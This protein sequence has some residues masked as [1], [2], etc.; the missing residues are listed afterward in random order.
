MVVAMQILTVTQLNMY[1]R[2]LLDTDPIVQDIWVEGEISNLSRPSSGHWYF[3]LKE[4]ESQV[5]AVAWK[6]YVA[7]FSELPSNGDAVLAHGR[8][9]LYE[10]SGQLQLYVDNLRPAGVGELHL[11]FEELKARL[12]AEGL[13]DASRKRPLPELPRRI[14]IV[15]SPTGAALRDIENVLRRRYPL[16]EVLLAGCQVQGAGAA[17]TIVEALYALYQHDLDVIIVA[18]G[19]GSIEDLWPFNEEIVAR[20][21]FASPIP[22]VSGV[23]HE[24]DTTM[25]DY[26]AD[27]RA[28]TPSAAA[29][30]VTP[31]IE[32]LRGALSALLGQL[33]TAIYQRIGASEMQLGEL[34]RRL[35]QR[36]PL[37]RVER[38][39]QTIDHLLRRANARFQHQIDLYRAR[40]D[41]LSARLQTLSPHATLDR[42]YAIVRRAADG[43][44]LS[45]ADHVA[46][47]EAIEVTLREGSFQATRDAAPASSKKPRR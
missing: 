34:Q 24:T 32:A 20:A 25:I 17:E 27:V 40:L 46:P 8:I 21:V 18:R 7:R 11:R 2:E 13:F 41:G 1:L 42:G 36:A 35:A 33:D 12:Q 10:A 28:P 39:R 9:S 6:S 30:I 4:G 5:R 29:E 37:A 38:D 14:G 43:Q 26:V 3:T 31:N 45:N 44:V 47:G 16:A 23:G 22:I 19:G 15:T